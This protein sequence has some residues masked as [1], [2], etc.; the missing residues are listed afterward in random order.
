M[1]GGTRGVGLKIHCFMA[2]AAQ[3]KKHIGH[4]SLGARCDVG[5][6]KIRTAPSAARSYWLYMF[7]VQW[8]LLTLHSKVN[9]S[10][11]YMHARQLVADIFSDI[12]GLVPLSMNNSSTLVLKAAF[13][14]PYPLVALPTS[15]I[16]AAPPPPAYVS[17]KTFVPPFSTKV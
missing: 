12:L 1:W 16:T 2:T 6:E 5:F 11:S 13:S 8:D 3:K 9:A 15:R 17:P 7:S 4:Y 10:S 14:H